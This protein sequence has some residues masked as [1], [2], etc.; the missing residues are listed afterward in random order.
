MGLYEL[1]Q[2]LICQ[3]THYT[4]ALHPIFNEGAAGASNYYLTGF[5]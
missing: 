5:D 4:A 2:T 3:G 1:D